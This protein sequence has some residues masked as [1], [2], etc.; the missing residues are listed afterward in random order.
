MLLTINLLVVVK[1]QPSTNDI[2]L[3]IAKEIRS[4]ADYNCDDKRFEL[5]EKRH[6]Q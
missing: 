5:L 2:R 4:R 6:L 3:L 1:D